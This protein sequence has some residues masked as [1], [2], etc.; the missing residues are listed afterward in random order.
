MASVVRTAIVVCGP[1]PPAA[2]V[3]A[4]LPRAPDLVIAADV[5]LRHASILGVA[6]DLLVGDLDSLDNH[7]VQAARRAGIVVERHPR[8]KDATDLELAILAAID[9][10]AWRV[11]VIDGGVGPRVDH[12]LA[13]VML[14][15]SPRFAACSV[16]GAI[17]DA[18]VTVI[19][20]HNGLVA[21]RGDVGSIVTLLAIGGPA[22]GVTTDGLRWNLDRGTLEPGSTLGVSNEITT[23]PALIEVD[24]GCVIAIQPFGGAP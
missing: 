3:A 4:H 10:G 20:D 8:F 21:L 13:N 2:E 24:A 6:V 1:V 11:I 5:G 14:L 18:W 17:G 15:A 12:F 9:R 7:E 16:E 22:R 19:R 23:A